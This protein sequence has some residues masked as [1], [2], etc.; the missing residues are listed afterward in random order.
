[1]LLIDEITEARIKQAIDRGELNDLPGEGSRLDLDDDVLVPE[2]LRVAYRILKN[3]GF[4]PEELALRREISDIHGLLHG[5]TDDC[6]RARAVKRL[7]ML[8]VQLGAARKGGVNMLT[9]QAYFNT[10]C[11]RFAPR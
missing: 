11:D 9:E 10:L 5:I 8:K 3:S 1:M 6:E 7:Q 2:Q 4:V